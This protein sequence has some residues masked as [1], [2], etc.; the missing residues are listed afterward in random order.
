MLSIAK[1][2]AKEGA[3]VLVIVYVVYMLKNALNFWRS[4]RG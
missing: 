3:V 2:L 4:N 1:D